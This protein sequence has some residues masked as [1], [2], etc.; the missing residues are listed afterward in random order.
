MKGFSLWNAR[1]VMINK[2]E[3][4][5]PTDKS[6]M[7]FDCFRVVELLSGSHMELSSKVHDHLSI[8]HHDRLFSTDLK[9]A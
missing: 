8:P 6:R 9:H 4:P 7:T 3:N 2:G 1:A 5:K